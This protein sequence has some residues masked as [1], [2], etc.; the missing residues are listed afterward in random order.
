[1]SH[2]IMFILNLI[3]IVIWCLL[4]THLHVFFPSMVCV[5]QEDRPCGYCTCLMSQSW[6]QQALD[7]FIIFFVFVFDMCICIFLFY[8]F[9]SFL[10]FYFFLFFIVS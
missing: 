5:S 8:F 9:S 3:V 10:C 4:A 6:L 2:T 7:F 1:M